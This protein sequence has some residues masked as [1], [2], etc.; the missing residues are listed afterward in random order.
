[1]ASDCLDLNRCLRVVVGEVEEPLAPAAAV[2]DEEDDD[3]SLEVVALLPV[4]ITL[5][6]LTTPPLDCERLIKRSRTR[7]KQ[8]VNVIYVKV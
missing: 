4:P 1:M 2:V 6:N 5:V 8:V 7:I 3:L